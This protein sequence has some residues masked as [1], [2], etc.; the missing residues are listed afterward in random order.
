MNAQ[1]S[2]GVPSFYRKTARK[3]KELPFAPR[4]VADSRDGRRKERPDDIIPFLT[5]RIARR[6]ANKVDRDGDGLFRLP[7][8]VSRDQGQRQGL[9][10]PEG[11]CDV[12]ADQQTDVLSSVGQR[13]GHQAYRTDKGSDD[14]QVISR[15]VKG[16]LEEPTHGITKASMTRRFCWVFLTSH[17]DERRTVMM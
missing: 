14:Q 6:P 7:R 1:V 17:N 9:S 4:N 3:A 5:Y 10:A 8:Y 11:E 2:Q 12:V 16:K 13:H 15:G